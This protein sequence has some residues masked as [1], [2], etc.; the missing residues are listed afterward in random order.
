MTCPGSLFFENLPPEE[1]SAPAKEGTA[2]GRYL[3]HIL[4]GT[5]PGT[6]C[7]NGVMFDDDMKFHTAEVAKR[8]L[9][10]SQGS[11]VLC[12]QRVDWMTQSGIPIRGQYDA[13]FVGFDGK[14]YVD[15]L[16]YGWGI[17]EV[18][19][20]WQLLG[21]AI[22]EVIR[23]QQAFPSIVLRIHQPRPHHEDGSTREWEISYEEL[24]SYKEM[25]EGRMMEIARGVNE[26]VTGPKCKYCP[27]A[28][29]CP[30]LNRALYNGIDVALGDFHQDNI[31]E[32]VL[33]RQLDEISR[34]EEVLKIRKDS[35]NALAVHRIQQGAIIPG[36]MMEKSYGDR[37][38]KPGV[39]PKAIE[40]LT[41]K[42]II[43]EKMMSPAQAEKLGISKEFIASLVERHFIGNKVKKGDAG[44]M[45]DKIFNNQ[46]RGA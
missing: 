2:A 27:A 30:A 26:L 40:V 23:R 22:G 31:S 25:I 6:H 32:A 24:L 20:N 9:E 13:S 21:Y 38:W 11:P 1:D 5:A 37:K 41:G 15:D 17:V 45:A 34:A 42:K 16:K 28:A 4:E 39:S 14:L 44:K 12:E 8:V 29:L 18:R 36:Y 46:Q 3:Q 35:L 19:N 43:E 7:E 33:A 10:K